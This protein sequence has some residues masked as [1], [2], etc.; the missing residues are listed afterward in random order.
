MDACQ[1]KPAD[2]AEMQP[3]DRP[4]DAALDEAMH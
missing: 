4:F 1:V 2:V 3:S